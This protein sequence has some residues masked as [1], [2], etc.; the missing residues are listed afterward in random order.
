MKQ[1]KQGYINEYN[2]LYSFKSIRYHHLKGKSGSQKGLQ[3]GNPKKSLS[4]ALAIGG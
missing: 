3:P 1:I 4:P 2:K